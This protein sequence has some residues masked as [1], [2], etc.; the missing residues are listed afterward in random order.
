MLK[1]ELQKL[2]E[3]MSTETSKTTAQIVHEQYNIIIALKNE[4]YTIKQILKFLKKKNILPENLTYNWLMLEMHRYRRLHNL[5][6]IHTH[7]TKKREVTAVS[8]PSPAPEIKHTEVTAK[9]ISTTAPSTDKAPQTE[10]VPTKLN[11]F[12]MP[13]KT[14]EEN[15]AW[16]EKQ[17]RQRKKR[18]ELR[19]ERIL[20]ETMEKYP[21]GKT[22]P[23]G[24]ASFIII[25]DDADEEYYQNL[26]FPKE[27]DEE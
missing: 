5:G 23:K 24:S 20:R 7:D 25:P 1:D 6:K 17:E 16:L 10:Q 14:D 15:K 19:K 8:T 11:M 22:M 12:G 3:E 9:D 26:L 13:A 21:P 18:D 27:T 2:K 4:G